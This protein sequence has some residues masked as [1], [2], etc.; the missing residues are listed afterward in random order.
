PQSYDAVEPLDVE[1]F[2]MMHLRSGDAELMQELGDFPDDEPDVEL[3]DREC[4]TVR[5][6]VPLEGCQGD[7][8]SAYAERTGF[9]K[10]LLKQTFESDIQPQR[11][12]EPVKSP[13]LTVLCDDEGAR[14]TLSSSDFDLRALQPDPRLDCLLRFSSPEELDRFNLESRHANRQP[15]LFALYPPS[16]EE[17]A[18]EIRPIPDCPKEHMGH[19]I[20]V[21]CLSIKFEIEIE[22]IFAT[23][24][25]YDLKEKKKISE[26]FHCDLNSDQ[27]KS[28]LRGHTPHTDSST[29]ARA[30]IFSISYPSPDIYLVIKIEKVLQQG[31]ISECAEPYMTMKESD[32]TKNKEKLEKLRSQAESSCQRLGQYRMPFAFATINIMSAISTV[33]LDRDTTDSDSVNGNGPKAREGRLDHSLH[34]SV[35]KSISRWCHPY[36]GRTNTDKKAYLP[37]RNSERFSILE[38]QYNLSSFKPGIITITNFFKQEG[39]RLSDEDLFKVLADLKRTSNIQRRV[40][41]IS[42]SVK[43]DVTPAPDTVAACLSPE[44]IPI[45]PVPEKNVRPI[46]EVL[47]FPSSDVY[48]PHCIYRNLLYVYPQRLNIGS[49]LASARNITVKIQFMNG[50]EASS[51]LPVIFGKSNGP[52]FVSETYTPVTY[53]NKSPDFYEEVKIRLPARLTEHHHL[54]FT[55]IHVSCQA[56]QSQSASPETLIGYSWLPILS[57]QRLQVGQCCLPIVQDRLPLNY[58]L[59]SPE[60]LPPQVPPV[61]WMESHKG[62]FSLELQAVSSVHTQDGYLERFFALCHALEGKAMFPIRVGEEKV[63]EH[64][65]EHELKLSIISLSAAALE[66]LVLFLHLV[67]DKL[68]HLI[69]QPMVIAGQ[70]ANLAQIAFESV[71]SVVNSLHSSQELAKDQQGRNC[72]LATYLYFVFRLPDTP[73]EVFSTG[74]GVLHQEAKY[75]TMG[76]AT[77]TSVGNMLLQS[78]IRS[79]SNPDIPVPHSTEDAEVKDIMV[80]KQFHE[81]LALQMV[82]STGVCRENVYKYAWFFFELLVKSMAQYVSQMDKRGIPRKSRFSDRFKDD[83]TTIVNVVTAEIGTILVKQQKELE[84]AEKVNISLAFF[85]YDLMSLMDRG[86]VFNLVRNY[87]NQ[88]SAKSVSMATLISMRLEFLRVL[89]SHEHYLNLSLY[90]SSPASAPA[91]PSPSVTSQVSKLRP[92]GVI[93][94]LTFT[95]ATYSLPHCVCV[96]VCVCVPVSKHGFCEQT[97]SSCS[98]Q[99]QKLVA[100]FDLSQ[101]FKQQH[102]LTGLILT[103]LSAALDTESDGGKVQRKAINATY[104]LLCAHDLDARC[105]KPEVRTKIAAL[106]LP[107]VGIIIDSINYLDFTVSDSRGS[108]GKAGGPEED[109]ENIP[110]INHSVAMAI[111]G[112]PFN[113]LARNAMVSMAS[114]SGKSCSTLTAEASR[115]LLACFLWVMKNAEQGLVQR[116]LADTPPA[117]LGRLL[118]LLTICVSC[119]EYRGKQS[120]DKVS[121]QALQK[122]QQAKARLEEALLGGMGARGEMMKRVG[123]NDRTLGQRENLRWRKDLTQWRQTNDRQDKSK[124]ELD[125]EAIIGGNLATEANLIVLD[126]LETIVQAVALGD[127]KDNAVGGV[128][129]V[130]LHSLTCNQSSTYL[131]HCFSTIRALIVKFGD[132]LFEEEAEQCADLCQKVLQYCSSCVDSNRSQ[133]C[134]TLYLIMR[135]SFG[136]ASNFSRVKMQVTMSLASLVGKSSDVR[137]EYLRRSFRTILS[138]AEEDSEMQATQLPA[139]VDELLKNLNSILLDTVKMKEFQEDPEMLMDLMYRIAK[140]YQTSPDLR[141]TWLQNMAEKHNGRKCFTESAMCLVHAAALVAEYLS[142]LEDHKYL[143][144]GSVTFQNISANV[145]EE[146]AVSDDILSPDEDG[147]C[148]GCYFTENGLVALLEQAAELFSNG[149]LYEAVNEVYKIIIPIL[150]AHRDFRKLATTHDNLKRAFDNIVHKGHKRMFGTYFRVAFFGSKFGDLDER[151]FIYKEP[152]ITHLPEISHR[153]ENFY[154]QCLGDGVLEMI[155]DSTPVDKNKLNAN[156][157]YIQITYV[158]PYFDDYEMKDRMTNFEKSFNLRRFMYTTPF[159]K[160]GRPRGELNEQYKRKTILTT[161]HAFPY[162]K[163]RINVIQKEEFDLTPI[164]VAIEDMQKKTRELAIATHKETPDAKMLQMVLQGSVTATVNQV[165]APRP[166]LST[167]PPFLCVMENFASSQEISPFSSQESSSNISTMH[168]SDVSHGPLEVA[169]VFLNEIPADP[170]L[171]RH[172]NKLRLCFKEF[173]LRCGEAVEKNKHLIASDQKEYQ[174]ELKKNY[175]KLREN[176]RPMLERKIPELYKPLVKPRMENRHYVLDLTVSFQRKVIGGNIVLFLEPARGAGRLEEP[177]SLTSSH[178]GDGDQR[179]PPV[180]GGEEA[181]CSAAVPRAPEDAVLLAGA[182]KCEKGQCDASKTPWAHDSEAFTLILDCCDLLVSAVEEVDMSSVVG[183]WDV[184]DGDQVPLASGLHSSSAVVQRLISVPSSRW[185]Q[186]QDMYL[187]CSRACAASHAEPLLFHTDRWSLQIRKTGVCSPCT[188]PCVLRIWY[189]TKPTGGSVRW[190]TDQDGSCC[191][192]TAGSPINNRALFP[193]QEP[194]VAMSTWRACVKAPCEYIA[195]LSGENQAVPWPGETGFLQWD[196]YVTMPMP[197][198]TFTIAVGRWQQAIKRACMCEKTENEDPS[199]E[200]DWYVACLPLESP[201]VISVSYGKLAIVSLC[202]NSSKDDSG[203]R[204]TKLGCDDQSSRPG[205]ALSAGEE[206]QPNFCSHVDYPCRFTCEVSRAQVIL[207][208][209]VFAPSCHLRRVE[210]TVLRL[211]P[212]C[213]AAAYSVLGVHPFSRLDLLIVPPGFSSLGM[214]SPHI[215]FLSQSVLAGESSLCGQRLCHEIAHSWFGLAIGAR[216]WTEEWI[217]EG[218]ATYLEDV[219][220]A[221][222]Q[223]LGD[224]EEEEQKDL[225]A[226]LRWRRLMDE[227]GN[228]EEDLQVLRPSKDMTGGASESGS[229]V[230]KHAL[231]P[232]K[233]FMQVHYLKGYFLLKFLAGEVGEREFLGFFRAFVMRFHGQLILSQDFLQ[234]SLDTFPA[235]SSRGLTIGAIYS[236]WLDTPGIPKVRANDRSIWTEM[237]SDHVSNTELCFIVPETAP[238]KLVAARSQFD[239]VAD[240]TSYRSHPGDI[241]VWLCD[242]LSVRDSYT[243]LYLFAKPPQVAKWKQLRGGVAKGTKRKRTRS[244]VN[245]KELRVEQLLLLLEFL[246]EEAELSGN[247]LGLLQTTYSL[248]RQDAELPEQGGGWPSAFSL[249]PYAPLGLTLIL[250]RSQEVSRKWQFWKVLPMLERQCDYKTRRELE[251]VECR[252]F[253]ALYSSLMRSARFPEPP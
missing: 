140:N 212:L 125:Q 1:E 207:P 134:A 47:E 184:L 168:Y 222:V 252:G 33:T 128:L 182:E 83:I 82:V 248:R 156:K 215:I 104:S 92:L 84:Q 77:A 31:D 28:F 3:V 235:L 144:V 201:S 118:E 241:S 208:H 198:S 8:L 88:M 205:R 90:F 87:C 200:L 189:E 130:L 48:V 105:S 79:S 54:L 4:R 46:K 146:S 178:P 39:E 30:A 237:C 2:L 148:S 73:L 85:L 81:E 102:Y 34:A 13:S 109:F 136:S 72:L 204:S 6:S 101:E 121:T 192:Y 157:A 169:Q 155:K 122:S 80:G 112:N 32:T 62:L 176:L 106:Y 70:T 21:R 96:C 190:T 203:S 22:P 60:K 108:K 98:L 53:H 119:L 195:L 16:D 159:T 251:A 167:T 242:L 11:P 166:F 93:L 197:A 14:N 68:F 127:C 5:H 154:S 170:K 52:E 75:S 57:N 185:K 116:W 129:R 63:P 45:K 36:R 206:G 35:C 86:F 249:S 111:A 114:V 214:A 65:L 142:M 181:R 26:N 20:L 183:L 117:Q 19:R 228:C 49:R 132:V 107:L 69:M 175:N 224:T 211:V 234:I 110:P 174:Q 193:C 179:P 229:S 147:V 217:S 246:L 253:L 120:S 231:N 186:Q 250:D 64:K 115:S 194:P 126:L 223:Q 94:L 100:M 163:T 187:Q 61:K 236:D 232:A 162:I 210:D 123:A 78:R 199:T 124:A 180:A 41:T 133:A 51:A 131:S 7:G 44:I 151:E 164:E 219:F 71:V 216:D 24:A 12:E 188:F 143:P 76:R 137:E 29:T 138:Y 150:E 56:R 149:G 191:V 196:Y 97:S 58:S 240:S 25:L 172:H 145:L 233:P 230:V 38:D 161:M 139:Q 247:C 91:S 37:R 160:S 99:D 177:P 135:Y 153:L 152:G 171:Y 165:R 238:S 220:W 23:M 89:C 18:V 103:E 42:G 43:L 244:K 59:H 158:E 225:K 95:F 27:M 202:C 9:H 50:E 245:F 173:L 55:F 17:D 221:R 213:L 243:L 66:P 67:L 10:L 113:T 239:M 218:F 209:R 40:K 15:E 226:L 141:L 227:M 74:Q